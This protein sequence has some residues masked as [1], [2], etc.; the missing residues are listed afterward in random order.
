MIYGF[1]VIIAGMAIFT[2]GP[3]LAGWIVYKFT[4]RCLGRSPRR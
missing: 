1:T 3:P 2:L 4:T